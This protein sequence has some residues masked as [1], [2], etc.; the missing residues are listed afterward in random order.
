MSTSI[1]DAAGDAMRSISGS[2]HE[3]LTRPDELHQDRHS[4]LYTFTGGAK[5]GGLEKPN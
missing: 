1:N 2:A 4:A 5:S 3:L